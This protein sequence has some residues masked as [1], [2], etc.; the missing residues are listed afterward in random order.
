MEKKLY[1]FK[2]KN[3]FFDDIRIK[4]LRKIAGGDTYTIIYLRMQLLSLKNGGTIYYEGVLESFAKELSLKLDEDED[5]VQIT[6]DY[7][8]KHG[9]LIQG[10]DEKFILPETIECIGSESSSVE[11]VRRYRE[12]QKK[13]L[14]EQIKSDDNVETENIP[15]IENNINVIRYGGNYY[16]VLKRDNYKCINC[17]SNEKICVHHLDGFRK[18]IPGNNQIQKLITLCK[19]CHSNLHNNNIKIDEK[20]LIEIGYY[21]ENVTCNADVTLD[22]K[23]IDN[24]IEDNK[25]NNMSAY[26]DIIDY[27]NKKLNSHYR[28]STRK[29]QT[30]INSRLRDGYTVEDFKT[31]IDKKYDEW[32]NTDMQKYLTPETLFGN[33]FEKYLQQKQNVKKLPNWYDDYRKDENTNLDIKEEKIE[34]IEDLQD[35]F[36]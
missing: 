21:S 8:K 11:R 1:W 31:V 15:I 7:L 18:D 30:L 17:G 20:K 32:N 2:F 26:A 36:K 3:D 22:N 5:D 19:K 25:I 23:I 24:K 14:L 6:I 10:T 13:L 9:L 16:S 4:K 35:F 29:N 33:K 34:N 27:L 12:K 28:I